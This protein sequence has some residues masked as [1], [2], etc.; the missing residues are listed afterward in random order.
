MTFYDG[1]DLLWTDDGDFCLG[2]NND[3]ADTSHDPLL[4]VAQDVYDRCKSDK[5][6]YSELA[7]IGASLS[8]FVGEPNTRDN[9]KLIEKRT[10]N[11]MKVGGPISPSDISLRSFP[12]SKHTLGMVVTLAVQPTQW[13]KKS[14]FIRMHLLYSYSENNVYPIGSNP[15]EEQ[16]I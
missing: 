3:M 12:I 15:L 8:D 16:L 2:R 13:N 1:I 5:G 4:A 9:A 6:D 11:A 7:N 14:Q 10:F